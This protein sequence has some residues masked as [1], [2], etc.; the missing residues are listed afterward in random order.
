[1]PFSLLFDDA[2]EEIVDQ[3]LIEM[4]WRIFSLV[5]LI[6]YLGGQDNVS[7]FL[8]SHKLLAPLGIVNN[9]LLNNLV[10]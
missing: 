6:S 8:G 10:S 3:S 1:L 5:E 7:L 4:D 2:L 9:I